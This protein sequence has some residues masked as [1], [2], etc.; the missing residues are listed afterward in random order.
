[1]AELM[2]RVKDTLRTQCRTDTEGTGSSR[3]HC[4]WLHLSP[5]QYI[6][7]Q[8]L[9]VT[10]CHITSHHITYQPIDMTYTQTHTDTHRQPTD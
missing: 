8:S 7:S 4:H 2:R 6:T 5:V 1:M 3:E 10:T 9:H